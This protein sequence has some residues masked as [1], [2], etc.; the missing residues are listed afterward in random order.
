MLTP[1]HLVA[2]CALFLMFVGVSRGD[3]IHLTTGRTIKGTVVKDTEMEVVVK[4]PKGK[5]TLPRH[6]V[7]KIVR[8]SKGKTNLELARQRVVSEDY[9]AA[10]TLFRKA[11]KDEDKDVSG[12]AKVELAQLL[13]RMR[14]A[15]PVEDADAP[16][17]PSRKPRKKK[18]EA[19]DG[20]AAA[21]HLAGGPFAR[22]VRAKEIVLALRA[23]DTG[24]ALALL[25][26]AQEE[27]ATDPS[28]GFLYGRTL[29]LSNKD[30]EAKRVY[31]KLLAGTKATKRL[32]VA[33]LG[34]AARRR[35]AGYTLD[36]DS[37]GIG[38]PWKRIQ[39]KHFAIYHPFES[40]EGWFRTAPE[41]ALKLALKTYKIE[42]SEIEF[43]GRIQ[44]FIFTDVEAYKAG[45]GMELAGGHASVRL[46]PDGLIKTISAYPERS[47]YN[48]TYR[49]EIAHT[50][51]L[52]AYGGIP[53]WAHEGAAVWVEPVRQRGR[54][55][56]VYR[57]QKGEGT[58][59]SLK[60]YLRDEAPRGSTQL[61]VAGYYAYASVAFETLCGETGSARKAL[62]VCLDIATEGPD[63]A[64][65]KV[66]LTVKQ[67]EAAME[68]LSK[69]VNKDR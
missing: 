24:K 56:G 50:V 49:H 29:E 16:P 48:Y 69:N 53:R 33:W 12:A 27:H 26:E 11:A 13:K 61:E 68:K 42:E 66:K 55:R 34:E 35:M 20:K 37:P 10:E 60:D 23:D 63:A 47:F 57:G 52:E 17:S 64:L 40:V 51:L 7:K 41:E 3:E 14:R 18:T 38:K 54:Y 5:L 58:L 8:Q 32:D 45:G 15:A 59:I 4:T 67:L 65:K 43:S 22:T 46:A 44:V 39:T 9:E 21:L 28:F 30:A 1:R 6:L 31:L 25:K 2:C 62:D 36:E 19:V